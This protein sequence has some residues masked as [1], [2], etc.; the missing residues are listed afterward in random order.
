MKGFL[1]VY[2]NEENKSVSENQKSN[3]SNIGQS[4]D[5]AFDSND[6]IYFV[7]DDYLHKL[8]SI[9]E[10]IYTYEKFSSLLNDELFILKLVN[11]I[12]F[13]LSNFLIGITL[14]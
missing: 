9:E 4:L 13:S 14:D 8:N 2:I 3:M 10:M 5:I 6:L 11:L 7:E 1:S 12:S